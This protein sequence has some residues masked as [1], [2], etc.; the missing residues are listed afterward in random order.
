MIF[1]LNIKYVNDLEI[2]HSKYARVYIIIII[3]MDDFIETR[4][5][6]MLIFQGSYV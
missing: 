6:K 3:I 2:S 1:C 4:L 5:K